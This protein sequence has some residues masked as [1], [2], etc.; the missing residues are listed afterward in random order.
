MTTQ[1]E[2]EESCQD[3]VKVK[4]E[5]YGPCFDL[6][7]DARECAAALAC[8][9]FQNFE[10]YAFAQPYEF[11]VACEGEWNAMFPLCD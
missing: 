6:I 1:M 5:N 11:P 7:L 10:D 3:F 9:E 2:C 8:D 4:G